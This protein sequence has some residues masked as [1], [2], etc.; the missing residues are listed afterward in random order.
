LID[1]DLVYNEAEYY[2]IPLIASW[3]EFADS[4][5]LRDQL[6]LEGEKNIVALLRKATLAPWYNYAQQT[7]TTNM[8]KLVKVLSRGSEQH[9]SFGASLALYQ[10]EKKKK[11]LIHFVENRRTR[12]R[13]CLV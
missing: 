5:E 6:D 11:Y 2:R 1:P 10:N 13:C 4:Q 12:I 7:I 3:E 8:P 9:G